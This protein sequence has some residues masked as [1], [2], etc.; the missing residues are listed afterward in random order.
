MTIYN[1]KFFN[2]TA[3]KNGGAIYSYTKGTG[4]SSNVLI[5]TSE[6]ENN[7]AKGPEGKTGGGAIYSFSDGTRSNSIV[8]IHN[9][10]FKNNRFEGTYTQ[11]GGGAIYSFSESSISN[12]NLNNCY[13]YN[14]SVNVN[15]QNSGGGAIYSKGSSQSNVNVNNSTFKENYAIAGG[16]YS[17]GGAIFSRCSASSGISSVKIYNNS[18]FENNTS[19]NNGGAIFS[20]SGGNGLSTIIISNSTFYKNNAKGT[21]TSGGG[22]I[23]SYGFNGG[24]SNI[25]VDA[26]IFYFNNA[27]SNG[28]AIYSYCTGSNGAS[29]VNINNSEFFNNS[30]KD[31]GAI[32]NRGED[33]TNSRGIVNIN[34][35][36]SIFENNTAIENGGA[37]SNF[38]K[39]N[40]SNVNIKNSELYNNK[41]KNGGAISGQSSTRSTISG[42][43]N[44]NL[45]NSELYKNVAD[46]NGGAIYSHGAG[47]SNTGG[48]SH[49]VILN[50]SIYDNNANNGGAIYGYSSGNKGISKI[51]AYNTSFE[52]NKATGNDIGGGAICNYGFTGSN[53]NISIYNITF[54]NNYANTNGGAIASSSSSGNNNINIYKSIFNKNEANINGG[55]IFISSST[56]NNNNINIYNTTFNSNNA[57]ENGGAIA[58]FNTTYAIINTNMDIYNSSF[59]NNNA[60]NGG[61]IASSTIKNNIISFKNIFYD[62]NVI[63]NGGAIYLK[64]SSNSNL[65]VSFSIFYN[66]H[67][68]NI[69]ETIYVFGS[70]N[71]DLSKNFWG[72]NNPNFTN[73]ININNYILKDYWTVTLEQDSNNPL[74]QNNDYYYHVNLYL[75]NTK[76]TDGFEKIPDFLVSI[77]TRDINLVLNPKEHTD[78]N[79]LN[80]IMSEYGNFNL[81]LYFENNLL[82]Q[83]TYTVKN[84]I[85]INLNDTVGNYDSVIIKG[86][87]TGLK[88][89][90]NVNVTLYINDTFYDTVETVNGIYIFNINNYA[91]GNYTIQIR[92]NKTEKYY[93]A[94]STSHKLLINQITPEIE[95][96]VNDTLYGENNNIEITITP[97]DATGNV[98]I[99]IWKN[100][101]LIYKNDTIFTGEKVIINFDKQSAGEYEIIVKYG[102]N[103]NYTN[104]SSIKTFKV[105]KNNLT[106]E[107]ITCVN[108]TYGKNQTVIINVNNDALGQIILN[109]N[110]KNITAEI[111]NGVVVFNDL[112]LNAG[113]YDCIITYNGDENYN[114]SYYVFYITVNKSDEHKITIYSNITYSEN[115]TLVV[116]VNPDMTGNLTL[117]IGNKNYTAIINN[118]VAKFEDLKLSVSNYTGTLSYKG[119]TNFNEFKKIDNIVVNKGDVLL[120]SEYI[121][122]YFKNGTNYTVKLTDSIGN[123]LS[124]YSIN[125]TVN[126]IVYTKI[127]NEKGIATL[128]INLLP[129]NYTVTAT[130]H[131]TSNYYNKTII[132]NLTVLSTMKTNNLVKY[133]LNE[134]QFEVELVDKQGK[135]LSN[136]TITFYVNGVMYNK[137]TNNTGIARLNINLY[138]GNYIITTTGPDGLTISNNITVKHTLIG[139]DLNKT[140]QEDKTYNVKVL[141]NQGQILAGQT[142]EINIHGIMY[143]VI[144]GID[145]IARLNI[146]LDPGSYIATATYNQYSTSNT[147]RVL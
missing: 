1:S 136:V 22:A 125:I 89:D 87:V 67:A 140:F 12:V 35:F 146:D 19:L 123:P 43:S 94:N 141:G 59:I 46:G 93:E 24:N 75:N 73:L 142:V 95:N 120:S 40:F 109:I 10:I 128:N 135:L 132:S 129:E 58:S 138:P 7:T 78:E 82:D 30:A 14:N 100:N 57:T 62:N 83:I 71:I 47:D 124:N 33:G 13:F 99:T 27:S 84:S 54:E 102:G 80:F 74:Q 108:M 137:T 72:D 122:M 39:G 18:V 97:S 28:G 101:T 64:N 56:G 42:G 69:N 55:G 70:N 131:G 26:S 16:T 21:G 85:N 36:N 121:I 98:N 81:T 23:Y 5:Y 60:N 44:I 143:S 126:G 66:N 110:G 113:D 144:T 31:G 79:S 8:T 133:Y 20:Q 134:T 49:I 116:N 103:T 127:T 4:T 90:D 147:I 117:T 104:V 91:A 48:I 6:F 86:N 45:E 119:D 25:T 130:F 139:Y 3:S 77:I 50:N 32:S 61:A 65:N 2:N 107:N 88:D 76:D 145:G 15:K 38:N 17:G 53:S 105:I 96:D 118:G 34:V 92:F 111:D 63:A 29:N 106:I 52:N 9:G 115:E 68:N 41:A 51:T 114:N 37:I 11:S 112:N